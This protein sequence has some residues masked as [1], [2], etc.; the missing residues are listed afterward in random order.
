MG[1]PGAPHCPTTSLHRWTAS[2]WVGQTTGAALASPGPGRLFGGTLRPGTTL[3]NDP[4]GRRHMVGLG[5]LWWTCAWLTPP[6][7][8]AMAEALP[9]PGSRLKAA[10]PGQ[11]A[12]GRGSCASAAGYKSL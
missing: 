6:T 9:R 4:H 12:V 11:G 7:T 10:R 1:G 8:K 3:E 2:R 5:R